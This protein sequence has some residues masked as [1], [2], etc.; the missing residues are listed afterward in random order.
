M[1]GNTEIRT[2]VPASVHP[3][4]V[5]PL[6]GALD[7]EGTPGRAAYS[8]ARAALGELRDTYA[9]IEDAERA[10]RDAE[11]PAAAPG[12]RRAAG[13]R[14]EELAEAA[15]RAFD[16]TAASVD[17]R[18]A[19]MRGARDALAAR[20]SEALADPAA[21]TP[22]GIAIAQEVR[23]HFRALGADER[24]AF[25]SAAVEAGDRRT[26]AALLSAPPYLSGMTPE[27]AASLRSRAADRWAPVESA[28]ARA[29][30]RAVDRV[31]DASRALVERYAAVV[32]RA[33][34]P[35]RA[36]SALVSLAGGRSG[37]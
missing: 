34:R 11:P 7:R 33:E 10:V 8:A 9:A 4:M 6:A 31:I 13:A 21:A 37:G 26:V 23:A 15:T 19:S 5:L 2:D 30:E 22:Q 29:L 3:D 20:L 36:R 25:L 35:A 12:L 28:Q 14:E 18:V 24:H 27:V 1:D 32:R 16:R 17:R